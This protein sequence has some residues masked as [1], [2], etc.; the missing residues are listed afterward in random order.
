MGHVEKKESMTEQTVLML[1]DGDKKM[2]AQH[3]RQLPDKELV[4][5]ITHGSNGTETKNINSA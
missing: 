2:L 1:S 3:K 5:I 4:D